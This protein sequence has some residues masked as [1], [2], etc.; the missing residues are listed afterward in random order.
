MSPSRYTASSQLFGGTQPLTMPYIPVGSTASATS[1][2]IF[3][4]STSGPLLILLVMKSSEPWSYA[5]FFSA[6]LN[7][8][9]NFAAFF[10]IA[11]LFMRLFANAFA[12]T[13]MAFLRPC[14]A[15][16]L[17]PAFTAVLIA[18]LNAPATPP[19]RKVVTTSRIETA[20]LTHFM[21]QS[22]LLAWQ[23]LSNPN[24][25]PTCKANCPS[26]SQGLKQ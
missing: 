19:L 3:R 5:S 25:Q 15:A 18:V 14:F 23:V 26:R 6:L 10:L 22:P 7:C 16:T 12:A 17:D 20:W 21:A 1:S 2:S 4:G 11:L 8:F 13:L 9:L 24:P